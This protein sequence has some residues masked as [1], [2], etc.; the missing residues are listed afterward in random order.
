MIIAQQ[1]LPVCLLF[2]SVDS[3]LSLGEQVLPFS[4]S[5]FLDWGERLGFLCALWSCVST[6]TEDK[7]TVTRALPRFPF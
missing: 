3:P 4:R 5:L 6:V 7:A 1:A 2:E